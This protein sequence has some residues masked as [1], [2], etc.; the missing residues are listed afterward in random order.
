MQSRGGLKLKLEGAQRN[1]RQV[2]FAPVSVVRAGDSEE[3]ALVTDS[4][5]RLRHPLPEGSYRLRVGHGNETEFGVA[6]GRWT[7]VRMRL[8]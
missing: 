2:R 6:G 8:P 4:S 7:L 5:G 3:I 1:D